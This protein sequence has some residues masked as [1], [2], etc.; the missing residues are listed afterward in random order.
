MK[1]ILGGTYLSSLKED[2]CTH[3]VVDELCSHPL[4]FEEL[5][6]LHVVKQEVCF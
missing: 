3:L 1:H 5:K 6:A 4:P 2:S